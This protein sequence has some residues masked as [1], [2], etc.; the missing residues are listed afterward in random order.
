MQKITPKNGS[1]DSGN[2]DLRQA[3]PS[4]KLIRVVLD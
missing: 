3:K 4:L 2:N 1:A